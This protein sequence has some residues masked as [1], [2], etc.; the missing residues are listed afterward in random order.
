MMSK[1]NIINDRFI[2]LWEKE[3]NQIADNDLAY[4]SLIKA[5]QNDIS[6]TGGLSEDTF[7]SLVR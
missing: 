3:F 6:S 4:D 2:E 5:A 1:K 7:K